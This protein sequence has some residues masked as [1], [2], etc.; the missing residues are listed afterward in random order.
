M[1]PIFLDRT[2]SEAGPYLPWK[3]RSFSAGA[4]LAFAGMYFQEDWLIWA[5]IAVL[6]LGFLLRY[7]PEEEEEVEEGEEETLL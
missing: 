6:F 5:A 2:R 4:V 1:S 7:A 3:V